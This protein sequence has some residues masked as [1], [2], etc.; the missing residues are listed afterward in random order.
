[1]RAITVV[2]VAAMLLF[3]SERSSGVPRKDK[4]AKP[5]NLL[6][7]GSFE[8]GPKVDA[9]G[10]KPLDKGSTEIKGWTVTRGQIDYIES[11]WQAAD[12]KRSIDLHGSPGFGGVQQT[13]ATK[14]GQLYRV[15]FSLAGTPGA[16]KKRVAVRAAGKKGEFQF[17]GS[18]TT[19]EKMDWEVQTWFFKA[20]A[21]KTTLEI[22][23]LE[24]TDPQQGPALDNVAVIAVEK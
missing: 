8:E 23:T 11:F 22:H 7:N 14:K 10:F 24:T 5:A 2:A 6:V 18:K 12:G 16:G 21:D 15:T 3:V 9:R 13:F 4:K 1:M 20:V 17:D 19:R